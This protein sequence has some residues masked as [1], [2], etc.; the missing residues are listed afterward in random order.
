MERTPVESTNLS[1][2]GYD[3]MTATLEIEFNRSGIYQYHG[4]PLEI[5]EGLMN[6][7]SKGSYFHENVRRA[8]YPCSKIG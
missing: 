2:V 4:V 6:S 7:G 5:Y 1:S 3:Q 8:G